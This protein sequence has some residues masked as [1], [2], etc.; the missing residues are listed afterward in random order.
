MYFGFAETWTA[1]RR[2]GVP[3]RG[4]TGGGQM[5]AKAARRRPLHRGSSDAGETEPSGGEVRGNHT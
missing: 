3:L 5:C 4:D 2:A 1:I